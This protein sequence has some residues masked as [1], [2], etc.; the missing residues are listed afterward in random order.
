[1][2]CS[3]APGATPLAWQAPKWPLKPNDSKRLNTANFY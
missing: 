1:V 3:K 2:D